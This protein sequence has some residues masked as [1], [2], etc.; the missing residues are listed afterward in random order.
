[1]I[2][3]ME[4]LNISIFSNNRYVP[5]IRNLN[6]R[7]NAGEILGV[8]GESGSGKSLTNMALMG[9]LPD[10]VKM[11]ASKLVFKGRDLLSFTRKNWRSIRGNEIA[12]VFQNPKSAMN[13]SMKIKAQLSE[14]IKKNEPGISRKKLLNIIFALL[15]RVGLDGASINLGSYPHELSNG[16]AQR[17]MIAMALSS[18]PSLLIADEITTGLDILQKR[19]IL[20]LLDEIR[21]ENNMAVL[22]VSHDINLIQEYTQRMHVMYSGELME[23]GPT[24]TLMNNP[25]HPYTKGLINCLPNEGTKNSKKHLNTIDGLVLPITEKTEGCRFRNRCPIAHSDCLVKPVVKEAVDNYD[26]SV[27]CHFRNEL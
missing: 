26:V 1:M 3:L 12:M 16:V 21:R 8:V 6:M 4:N 15:N 9:L 14:C 27:N 24:Q 19:Q 11:D 18:N 13:P 23:S 10:S 25:S 7:I 5:I 2:L 20:Q 17:I 22:L